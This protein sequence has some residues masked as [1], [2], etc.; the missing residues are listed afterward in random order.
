VAVVGAVLVLDYPFGIGKGGLAVKEVLPFGRQGDGGLILGVSLKGSQGTGNILTVLVLPE[1]GDIHIGP[2]G[3]GFDGDNSG[4]GDGDIG[5]EVIFDDDEFVIAE[6][7]YK[8][9]AQ[10]YGAGGQ[11]Q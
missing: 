8:I 11:E 7:E 5:L 6:G 3:H 1:Y 10:G 9:I 2:G 4:G